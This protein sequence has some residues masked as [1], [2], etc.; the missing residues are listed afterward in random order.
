MDSDDLHCGKGTE[1]A[2]YRFQ[3]SDFLT[4]PPARV[5]H[6][7]Y[8]LGTYLDSC[9]VWKTWNYQFDNYCGEI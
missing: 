4:T 6:P 3:L 5:M 1:N 7:E 9:P 8:G 2:K